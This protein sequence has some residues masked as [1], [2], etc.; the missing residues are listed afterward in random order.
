MRGRV[1]GAEV[2]EVPGTNNVLA[3]WVMVRSL[4]WSGCG[5]GQSLRFKSREMEPQILAL[6]LN[7]PVTWANHPLAWN[8]SLSLPTVQG[9]NSTP[10][11]SLGFLPA[12]VFCDP[13]AVFTWALDE[14]ALTCP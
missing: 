10:E 1:V 3:Y 9:R 7:S 11:E 14:Q 2:K 5:Q 6:P 12:G 4:P 13:R 8:L